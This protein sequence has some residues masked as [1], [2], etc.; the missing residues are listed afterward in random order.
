[1]PLSIFLLIIFWGDRISVMNPQPL[2][3][4]AS[5]IEG[6]A[7]YYETDQ[8]KIRLTALSQEDFRKHMLGLNVKPEL[9]DRP[10]VHE[11]LANMVVFRLDLLNRGGDNMVFNP[12]QAMLK[13]SRGPDGYVADMA[14]FWPQNL[15]DANIDQTR[16]AR[17]F[18]RGTVELAP[19]EKHS[20]LIAFNPVKKKFSKRVM[21]QLDRLY[22]GI[23]TFDIHCNFEI[24][25]ADL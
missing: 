14:A 8:Y 25:Y 2:T 12:D 19:G 7:V 10:N 9:I 22:Y 1:M 21:L 18:Q 6:N 16:L 15:P 11:L 20:Q 3:P 17:V 24:R 5:R 4:G 23:E 13:A